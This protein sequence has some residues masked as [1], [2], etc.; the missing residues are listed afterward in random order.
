MVIN[1]AKASLGVWSL[2]S[3]WNKNIIKCDFYYWSSEYIY[4]TIQ[5]LFLTFFFFLRCG[6][7]SQSCFFPRH[8]IKKEKK[9]VITTFYLTSL[10]LQMWVYILHIWLSSPL[11]SEFMFC[12]II[13]FIITPQ[14]N[15]NIYIKDNCDFLISQFWLCSCNCKF[16]TIFQNMS[17]TQHYKHNFPLI[18]SKL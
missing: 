8:G 7:S 16:V 6:H 18:K 17:Y 12:N 9:G 5:T 15:T 3:Q 11:N 1:I 2:F 4:L 10:F 13:F 14:N